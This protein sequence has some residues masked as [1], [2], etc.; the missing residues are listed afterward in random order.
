MIFHNLKILFF[1]SEYCFLKVWLLSVILGVAQPLLNQRQFC[2][3]CS[4]SLSFLHNYQNMDVQPP[5]PP[6]CTQVCGHL[7]WHFLRLGTSGTSVYFVLFP[8]LLF[9]ATS[10][11]LAHKPLFSLKIMSPCMYENYTLR[12]RKEG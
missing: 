7:C 8:L 10:K 1:S 12:E 5:E 3:Q 6:L 4:C 9:T 2:S 11:Y